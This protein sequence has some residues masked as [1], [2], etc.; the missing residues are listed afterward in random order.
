MSATIA[1]DLDDLDEIFREKYGPVDDLGWSPKLRR[2]FG[3]F[4]PDEWYEAIVSKLVNEKTC[5]LDV[6][7]GRS[8]FPDNPRLALRLSQQCQ[9]LV[10]LDPDPTLQQNLYVHEKIQGT[11]DQYDDGRQF[12]LVTMRMVAE[13][14]ADPQ[15]VVKGLLRLTRP[16]SWIVIYTIYR[17]SP[18]PMLTRLIPFSLHHPIKRLLWRT[19]AKDTFPVAYKMN[20]RE[21]LRRLFVQ[22][23]F[24]EALFAYLDD[25]RTFARFRAS[26]YMELMAQRWLHARGLHYPEVC[27]LA[28]YQRGPVER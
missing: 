2:N 26:H 23:G 12:D 14:V 19:E 17:W 4:T 5:W 16:G 27:L 25:C 24:V 11:I 22:Q 18:V 9:R 3:Y 15:A 10:G 28:V 6:G 21:S 20:T 1:P 13:H 7:C 8:L